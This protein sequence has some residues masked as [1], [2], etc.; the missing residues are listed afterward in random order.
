MRETNLKKLFAKFTQKH[1]LTAAAIFCF[2]TAIFIVSF[3]AYKTVFYPIDLISVNCH[4]PKIVIS[5]SEM[6]HIKTPDFVKGIYITAH[7]AGIYRFNELLELVKNTELNTMV[8][9]VQDS[10]GNLAFSPKTPGLSKLAQNSIL[11]P[12]LENIIK[13]AHDSNIYLIARVVVFQN[14]TMVKTYPEWA[15]KNRNGGLWKDYKGISWLDPAC[16]KSWN[17]NI[18]LAKELY[19]RGFDEINF[20]YIRFPTDGNMGAAVYPCFQDKNKTEIMELFFKRLN[21][22]LK[23]I[24]ISADL[25]GQTCCNYDD[26]NI[27]QKIAFTYGNVNAIC[28]MMYPSH[29]FTNFAGFKNPADHPYEVVKYSLDRTFEKINEREMA[30]SSAPKTGIER[31][32]KIR[33]WIQAFS[34]GA[35]YTPEMI[36]K[37]MQAI[38]DTPAAKGWLL[39]N[40][41]NIYSE[42]IFIK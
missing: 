32:T 7:T 20:D 10:K 40:A 24:P 18:K 41:S 25:F 12:N 23:G 37:Q 38:Y 36:R 29:Y 9:D 42:N 8:V 15:V 21:T 16:D 33:P 39:W 11:I 14:Q 28:Q 30:T 17:I 6:P 22:D 35:I 1:V 2:A 4:L 13:K 19:E 5:E 31:S 34:L 27:G 3:T 26:I